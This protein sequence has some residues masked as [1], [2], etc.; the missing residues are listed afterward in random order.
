MTEAELSALATRALEGLG[1][2]SAD[3]AQVAY[4]LVMG[5]LFGHA[6]HGVLRLESYGQR[7]DA[8]AIDPRAQP[9]VEPVAPA[10][11]RCP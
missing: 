2:A 3:A 10:S 11:M 9:G 5:D 1:L 6:T 4:V 7:I 8:G